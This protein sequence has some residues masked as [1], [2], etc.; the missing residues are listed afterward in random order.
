M[1]DSSNREFWKYT[2]NI[3]VLANAVRNK[4]GTDFY[5][6]YCS[7]IENPRWIE[8]PETQTKKRIPYH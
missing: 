1:K 3:I 2:E 6:F 7:W 5:F 8:L 4:F